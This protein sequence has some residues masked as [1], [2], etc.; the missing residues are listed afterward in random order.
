MQSDAKFARLDAITPMR[1][2][3]SE[4]IMSSNMPEPVNSREPDQLVLV[5]LSVH[6]CEAWLDAV[7]K[8]G[9]PWYGEVVDNLANAERLLTIYP[10]AHFLVCYD[11]P[12]QQ[13]ASYLN[14]HNLPSLA[15]SSWICTTEALLRTY[16]DNVNRMTLVQ[17]E[18]LE[19]NAGELFSQ[20]AAR[21]GIDLFSVSVQPK[22]KPA[23]VDTQ[24][25][26]LLHLLALQALQHSPGRLLVRELESRTLL[27]LES[28]PLL[29][30]VDN[31]YYILNA[32]FT[33]DI[34]QEN[35]FLVAQLHKA[36]EELEQYWLGNKGRDEIEKLERDIKN[37]NDKLYNFSQ[38]NKELLKKL[39]SSRQEVKEMRASKSW[40]VTAPLRA[41]IKLLSSKKSGG[42]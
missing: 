7:R 15:L 36:Q 30:W 35:N 31:A 20:L 40:K 24:G 9:Q 11:P 27:L 32:G 41:F 42:L 8:A 10:K 19:S 23:T 39:R 21:S 18:V 1:C 3:D 37:K 6:S 29:D 4:Y 16:H 28:K 26:T 38:K 25:Q 17:R 33:G 13:V 2:K 22:Q 5:N 14:Q 34:Q 12:E